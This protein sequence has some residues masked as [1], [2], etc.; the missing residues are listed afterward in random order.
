MNPFQ[1][2]QIMNMYNTNNQSMPNQFSNINNFN[3]K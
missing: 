2:N 3:N 1:M